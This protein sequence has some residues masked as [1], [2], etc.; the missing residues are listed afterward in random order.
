MLV[1]DEISAIQAAGASQPS[2][3]EHSHRDERKGR[4]AKR[5]LDC[6]ARKVSVMLEFITCVPPSAS[7]DISF[8]AT[9]CASG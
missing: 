6:L 5:S 1:A 7:V 9:S 2:Q 3:W 4:E 8:S